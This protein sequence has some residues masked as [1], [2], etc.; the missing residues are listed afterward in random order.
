MMLNRIPEA[1]E[2]F[3]IARRLD[4]LAGT[5]SV[6]LSYT[7]FLAGQ[8]DSALAEGRRA[9]ELDPDLPTA[10]IFLATERAVLGDREQARAILKGGF[11]ETP[12]NGMSAYVFGKIG[13]TAEVTRILSRL[14]A[15]PR[16]TWM[17]N[18]AKVYAYLGISRP[19]IAISLLE[20]AAAAR[21]TTPSWIFFADPGFD[22]LRGTPRF[23]AVLKAFRIENRGLTSKGGRPVP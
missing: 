15:L 16:D 19:D 11:T 4:P 12:W 6:W 23:A 10:R 1:L 2:Q 17:I 20:A 21:E 8:R 3:R 5:A 14:N 9:L 7:L 13:D 22:P 18:T